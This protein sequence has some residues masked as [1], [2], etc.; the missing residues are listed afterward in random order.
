METQPY[1]LSHRWSSPAWPRSSRRT[2]HDFPPTRRRETGS[3]SSH[4]SRVQLQL[5]WNYLLQSVVHDLNLLFILVLFLRVLEGHSNI[6]FVKSQTFWCYIWM[7][8]IS[9][10]ENSWFVC[11]Y[12]LFT[13]SDWAS[14]DLR[15][16]VTF[17]NS[18]SKSPHF[19]WARRNKCVFYGW[20]L[21]S[22][23][24]QM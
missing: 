4:S 14:S 12:Q 10:L 5:G 6:V 16:L 3:L 8:C 2:R 15:L 7:L 13:F 22:F 21:H 9:I 11:S 19:L 17:F 24:F 18:S 20:M 1:L 23:S